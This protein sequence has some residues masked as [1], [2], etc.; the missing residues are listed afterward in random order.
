METPIQKLLQFVISKELNLEE[1]EQLE[2]PIRERFIITDRDYKKD[3]TIDLIQTIID[4][5]KNGS[6]WSLE[7]I[8]KCT[9]NIT[10]K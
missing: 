2:N 3:L 6:C 9:Y 8:L 1:Y 5:E 7:E 4:W 10:E